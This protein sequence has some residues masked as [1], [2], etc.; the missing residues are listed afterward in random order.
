MFTL[1]QI[2]EAHSRVK[3]GTDFPQYIRELKALG[4]KAYETYVSD[5]H[6]EFFNKENQILSS[7][8]KYENLEVAENCNPTQFREYLELHQQGKTDYPTFCEHCAATGIEKWLVDL[9]KS[10]CVYF[11][12]ENVLVFEEEIPQ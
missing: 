4:V 10:T 1:Q 2:Q 9:E 11:A 7:L 12:K 5:G 6:S 3:S 8:P